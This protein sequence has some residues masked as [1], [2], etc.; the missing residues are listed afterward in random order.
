MSRSSA[1]NRT[2]GT[3]RARVQGGHRESSESR[4]V[5]KMSFYATWGDESGT[6]RVSEHRENDERGAILLLALIYIVAVSVFVGALA[7]W[8]TNDLNNT[9]EFFSASQIQYAASSATDVAVQAIRYFPQPPNPTANVYASVPTG[10]PLPVT[11]SGYS[12]P[13]TCWSVTGSTVEPAGAAA[14]TSSIT[15][16]GDTL[17]TW[18]S[19]IEILSQSTGNSGTRVVTVN[20]CLAS[21]TASQCVAAPLLTAIVSFDDYPVGGGL[22][23]TSQCNV[24]GVTCGEGSTIISWVKG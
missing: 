6:R 2:V 1:L 14:G 11:G 9:S 10:T 17:T 3:T 5:A 24:E 16:G 13:G 18:C 8:A 20:T 4:T 7:Y 23:L 12:S 21:Q 22:A 15:I 19:T